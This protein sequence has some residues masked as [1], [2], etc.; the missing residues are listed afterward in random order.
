VRGSHD[1]PL[2]VPHKVA[3]PPSLLAGRGENIGRR[4]EMQQKIPGVANGPEDKK[5]SR[6]ALFSGFEFQVFRL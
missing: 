6:S 3:L 2:Y 5:G 4:P 1:L